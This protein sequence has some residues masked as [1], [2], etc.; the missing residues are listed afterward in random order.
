MNKPRRLTQ[1]GPHALITALLACFSSFSVDAKQQFST[2]ELLSLSLEQLAT[3]KVS[4]VSK[5]DESLLNAAA[6]I[7]VITQN[8]IHNAG[9]TTIPEALRLAPNLHVARG[10]AGQYA[11][12]ARGFNSA[13][14]NKMLV[15]I[16]GRT[17]YSPFFAGVFWIT[18]DILMEDIERIEVISGPGGTMWG[19]NAV[20]GVINI[21]TH[22]AADTQG[23]L[24]TVN[25]A[26]S[27]RSAS[28]RYGGKL[29][30]NGYYRVYAKK[31]SVDHTE[32]ANGT[33]VP[34]GFDRTRVGFRTDWAGDNYQ[35]TVQGD[36]YDGTSEQAN[37]GETT[38]SGHNLLGRFTRQFENHSEL[39]VQSYYDLAVRDN[40][41]VFK[42]E[43]EIYDLELQYASPFLSKSRLL[44][45]GGYRFAKDH[46][47][48]NNPF[49][50]FLPE[51]KNLKWSNFFIQQET[52]LLPNLDLTLGAKWETNVYT[53][54][55]FLPNLRLAWHPQKDGLLWSEISRAVRSPARLDRDFSIPILGINGGP[56][57]Q[58]EV[59]SVLEIGYRAQPAKTLS[60]SFTAFYHQHDK[61]RSGEPDTTKPGFVVSNTIEGSTKGVEGWFHYQA[62]P[63]WRLSGGFIEQRQDLRNKPGSL[64]PKGPS[65]LENDPKHI[66]NLQSTYNVNKN[67]Q[68]FVLARYVSEL[69]NPQAPAYT[70]IDARYSWQLTKE[71]ELALSIQNLFDSQHGEF[72][73]PAVN[74]QYAQTA[75]ISL[76]W[77]P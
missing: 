60:Y 68:L 37:P 66:L 6:S 23:A 59:S 7:Y 56:D 69:P 64:D 49:L 74:S 5:Q 76:L 48:N 25:G 17:I 21:I 45:G 57:F 44:V 24:A 1:Y 11:I 47:T 29:G 4:T 2:E 15:L 32:R 14:G 73:D 62:M 70:A 38:F 9:V 26:S 77:Q 31:M 63:Q 61:Q 52:P 36:L 51:N 22:N 16:D 55:E 10:D 41:K 58:S 40:Q 20:N 50:S 34:D 46:T 33:A 72:G 28:A 30:D 12:S 53:G 71:C 3:I 13:L 54:T 18:Q 75:A 39:R 27:E 42:D 43:M 65:A 8:D 35:A 19:S 67:Q